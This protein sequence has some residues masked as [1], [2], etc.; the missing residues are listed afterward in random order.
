MTVEREVVM[1]LKAIADTGSG[2][3]FT[4]IGKQA[5]RARG[6]VEKLGKAQQSVAKESGGGSSI[7][8][9]VQGVKVTAVFVAVTQA[10]SFLGK[11]LDALGK[12]ST[13]TSGKIVEMVEAIPVLGMIATAAKDLGEVVSGRNIRRRALTLANID[14][15]AAEQAAGIGQAGAEQRRA[16]ELALRNAQGRVTASAAAAQGIGALAGSRAQAVVGAVFA[17]PGTAAFRRGREAEVV[18]PALQQRITAEANL[19]DAKRA[20]LFAA[21]E[22]EKL[23]ARAATALRQRDAAKVGLFG[24]SLDPLTR[25]ER[26]LKLKEAEHVAQRALDLLE[27]GTNRHKEAGVNLAQKKHDFAKAEVEVMKGRLALAKEEEDRAKTFQAGFAGLSRA[28]KWKAAHAARQLSEFGIRRLSQQQRGLLAQAGLGDVVSA[29]AGKEVED[30]PA[31]RALAAGIRERFNIRAVRE[32]VQERVRLE[33]EV[34]VKVERDNVELATELEKVMSRFTK[35]L[36][37][38]IL[39]TVETK[40]NLL[41]VDIDRQ[42][43]VAQGQG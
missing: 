22:L 16:N 2:K 43:I 20:Q 14:A 9:L 39:K 25:Q 11:S 7:N 5:D 26:A 23:E 40:I 29:A 24:V 31:F 41:S 3:A 8:T 18:G 1:R 42:R 27:Q 33:T 37:V 17:A 12:V 4:D 19:V 28:D 30:D 6:E 34:T 38:L 15:A 10:V 36:E 21:S 32:A 35:N 13:N